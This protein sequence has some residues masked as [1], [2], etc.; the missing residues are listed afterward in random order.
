[1]RPKNRATRLMTDIAGFKDASL[2][3]LPAQFI[4]RWWTADWFQ[5][6]A[7]VGRT[8]NDEWPLISADGDTALRSEGTHPAKR[9]RGISTKT[10]ATRT[11]WPNL[12]AA[13]P[14]TIRAA[15]G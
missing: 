9:F 15:R 10:R 5:P 4:L 3:H 11:D 8:G 1:M 2:R 14:K 13:R 6:I 12:T 7:K